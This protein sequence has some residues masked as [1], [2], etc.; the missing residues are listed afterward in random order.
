MK[1]ATVAATC[2]ALLMAA[3]KAVGLVVAWPCFLMPGAPILAILSRFTG[4]QLILESTFA[5]V[6]VN[7]TVY[8]G[9]GGIAGFLWWHHKQRADPFK[10]K[11]CDYSLV[12]NVSGTC[13]ECGT[14]I[15]AGEPD[16][17]QS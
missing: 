2:G 15:T 12:G 8:S 4:S 13:P 11:K 14:R 5:I 7:V 3:A 16:K 9:I 17:A 6:L 1:G 10:C